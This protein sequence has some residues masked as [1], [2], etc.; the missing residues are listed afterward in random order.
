MEEL[1]AA[2]YLVAYS[3]SKEYYYPLRACFGV[4]EVV[5]WSHYFLSDYRL[6]D[7]FVELGPR[8]YR[9]LVLWIPPSP[10]SCKIDIDAAIRVN[11]RSIGL[12]VVIRD[13]L[14]NVLISA[15]KT[16]LKLFSLARSLIPEYGA[17][18]EGLGGATT[19]K[20]GIDWRLVW[21]WVTG[22]VTVAV[23]DGLQR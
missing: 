9:R 18:A 1:K 13:N 5:R 22:G 8:E 3:T 2:C 12:G 15:A 14:R 16:S 17:L 21:T 11:D 6:A 4:N 20:G 19:T 7:D 23:V 10:S